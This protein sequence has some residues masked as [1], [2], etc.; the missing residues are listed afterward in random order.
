MTSTE[1]RIGIAYVEQDSPVLPGTIREN[2]TIASP[3]ATDRDCWQ[4]LE[5]V[6]L[7]NLVRT[8]DGLDAMVGELGSTLSGG[9]RQRLAISRAILSRPRLLLLDEST[10][11][12]EGLNETLARQA[13]DNLAKNCTLI[14]VAHRLATVVDADMIMVFNQGRLIGSGSHHELLE[15]NELYRALSRNQ[16]IS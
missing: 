11:N 14:V 13:I 8:P 6:N 7:E 2:L 1:M 5:A 10:S 12:L 15:G 4:A 3:D 16:L 9:E